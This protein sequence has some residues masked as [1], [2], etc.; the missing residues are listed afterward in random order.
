MKKS[1]LRSARAVNAKETLKKIE[2][3]EALRS[4]GRVYGGL[5][6]VEGNVI[7]FDDWEY[8]ETWTDSYTRKD[9]TVAE[10]P[11]VKVALGEVVRNIPIS[12][13]RRHLIGQ[14]DSLA[15]YKALNPF[16]A[17]LGTAQDDYELMHTCAG[18]VLKVVGFFSARTKAWNDARTNVLPYK[19]DD[20]STYDT[21]MWPIFEEVVEE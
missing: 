21:D 19:A 1:D 5:R 15:A 18:K 11:V 20:P 14:E 7:T 17:A 6:F 12:S 2:N 16:L 9:G 13:F 8:I 3:K 10:F 4:T